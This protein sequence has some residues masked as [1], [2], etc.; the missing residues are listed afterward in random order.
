M[1]KV[2]VRNKQE[3]TYQCSKCDCTLVKFNRWFGPGTTQKIDSWP[4]DKAHEFISKSHTSNRR[5]TTA[6]FADY[7][8]HYHTNE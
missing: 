5:D 1:N 4:V 8:E 6:M 2:R 7:A 3:G